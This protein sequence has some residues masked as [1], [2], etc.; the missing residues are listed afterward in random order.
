MT[1][2][3]LVGFVMVQVVPPIETVAKRFLHGLLAGRGRQA[4]TD[5]S[6]H[7]LSST[8][9]EAIFSSLVSEYTDGA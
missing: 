6:L 7:D 5:Q 2:R 1:A 4:H 3:A 9:S 8:L